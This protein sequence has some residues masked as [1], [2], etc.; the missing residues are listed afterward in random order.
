MG[1]ISLYRKYRPGTFEEIVGQSHITT[2]LKH[3]IER[4]RIA[5]AYLFSGPRGT[6][7]TS[8]ARILAKALN[9]E[10][11]PTPTPCNAC[12][13]CVSI[14]KDSLFDVIEIDAASNRQIEDIRD[15]R[16]KVRFPP[17]QA[18]F[19]VYIIDE[20]HMLTR[21]ACNALLK[22]LE[23]PP[24]HVIFVLATTEPQRLPSTILSRC[25]RFDFRRLSDK[26]IYDHILWIAGRENFTIEHKALV[27]IVKAAD[28]SLRDAISILDQLVSFSDGNITLPDVN[29]VLGMPERREITKLMDAVF[30]GDLESSFRLFNEFFN[31]GKSFSQFVRFLM[32]YF[33]DL[34]LINQQIRPA[35][36]IY[37]DEEL[38]PLKR[39]A[40]SLPREILVAM[41]DEIARVEDRIRWETYPRIVLEILLIKLTDTISGPGL[42]DSKPERA[43][44]SAAPPAPPKRQAPVPEPQPEPAYAAPPP[45]RAIKDTSPPNPQPAE[46]KP[47]PP[48]LPPVDDPELQAARDAWLKALEIIKKD[49]LPT[50]FIAVSAMPAAA[51]AHSV[52]LE[53]DQEHRFQMENISD[54]QYLK[55]IE[56]ALEQSLGRAVRI[57]VRLGGGRAEEIKDLSTNLHESSRTTHKPEN[58]SLFDTLSDVFPESTELK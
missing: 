36:E 57:K 42:T 41:L 3:A 23:E 34:Y 46:K 49:N 6:G 44:E 9:C 20:V 43:T 12:D 11:G 8:N 14:N 28:G 35:S 56:S 31:A 15:L 53:Y 51:D 39:Q 2:T 48:A 33:R 40:S 58:M 54:G 26:G 27:T 18:R 24:A 17:A 52:T 5:H 38:K 21:D 37:T 29:M 45:P 30:A 10:K 55:Q 4:N 7:K 50:Y 16:E 19:K 25:Q 1:Y 13:I 32:E 47:A 22:T